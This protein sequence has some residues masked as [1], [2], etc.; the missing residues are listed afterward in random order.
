MY[1]ELEKAVLVTRMH[2]AFYGE[3]P[4]V[5]KLQFPQI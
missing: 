5:V 3:L 1:R 2:H 4:P